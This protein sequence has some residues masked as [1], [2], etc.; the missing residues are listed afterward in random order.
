MSDRDAREGCGCVVWFVFFFVLVAM[1][2][3][4]TVDGKHYGL[5]GCSSKRG[6]V[7]DSGV[8]VTEAKE[9]VK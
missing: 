4:V 2:C 7:I 9:E 1:C 6:L 3:G 5:S 8:E